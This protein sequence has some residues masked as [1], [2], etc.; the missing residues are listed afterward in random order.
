LAV[1]K[2]NALIRADFTEFAVDVESVQDLVTDDFQS[3][4]RRDGIVAVVLT[5]RRLWTV[6][7]T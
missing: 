3:L 6:G 4:K 2:H 5:L 7:V 1:A